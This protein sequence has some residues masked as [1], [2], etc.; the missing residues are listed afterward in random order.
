MSMS[1]G[2]LASAQPSVQEMALDTLGALLRILGEYA[3]DQE[4]VEA[5]AFTALAEQWAKHVVIGAPPPGPGPELAAAEGRRDWS[6]VREFVREYCK[7]SSGHA[8]SVITDLR[9]VVWVFI[10]NLNQTMAQSAQ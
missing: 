5:A 4:K 2:R 10:Q 9:Q 6:G 1:A 7:E 3:L 8:R